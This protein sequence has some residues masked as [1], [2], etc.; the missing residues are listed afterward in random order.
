MTKRM[1]ILGVVLALVAGMIIPAAVIA[2]GDTTDV[3]GSILEATIE[4]TPPTDID[5]GMLTWGNNTE[6]STTGL[7][8]TVTPNSRNPAGVSGVYWDVTAKD[9]SNGGYMS[10]GGLG[11]TNLTNRLQ[12]GDDGTTWTPANTGITYE[13]NG[14]VT[15]AEYDFYAM[16]TIDSDAEVPGEY[17]ITITFTAEINV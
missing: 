7:N 11:V 1:L 8:V 9:A 10:I 3:T 13:G 5:F 16:Q 12:I 4:I 15:G 2:N 14:E 6:Q 17:S